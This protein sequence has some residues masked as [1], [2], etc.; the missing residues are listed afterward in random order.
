MTED[1]GTK[2]AE[3][4]MAKWIQAEKAR[5]GLLLYAVVCPNVTA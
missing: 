2:G 3:R 4:F 1:G 5:A